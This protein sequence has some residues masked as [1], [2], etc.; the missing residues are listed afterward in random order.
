V[1]IRYVFF[2]C[3]VSPAT[4]LPSTYIHEKFCPDFRSCNHLTAI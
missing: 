3:A 1:D 2:F 4:E